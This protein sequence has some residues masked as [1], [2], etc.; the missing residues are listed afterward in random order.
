MNKRST[1][2]AVMLLRRAIELVEEKPSNTLHLLF[3]DW[4]K[5]FDKVHP[6]AVGAVLRRYQAPAHLVRVVETLL[7][8]P[9]FRVSMDS[10][11]SDWKVQ[12]SGIRQGCTLSPFLFVLLLSA[13][14]HD[15]SALVG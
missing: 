4:E 10:E 9:S 11:H 13:V 7:A 14:M 1:L 6:Q 5:A 3:I 8:A 15:V 12:S 2:D